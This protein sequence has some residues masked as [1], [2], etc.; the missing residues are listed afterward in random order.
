MNP[1]AVLDEDPMIAT[2]GQGGG[3]AG[4]GG[5]G[6]GGEKG[7]EEDEDSGEEDERR[8]SVLATA[9]TTYAEV[10]EL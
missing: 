9:W 8:C 5:A 3:G 7:R 2:R 6:G 4:G 1:D 10:G